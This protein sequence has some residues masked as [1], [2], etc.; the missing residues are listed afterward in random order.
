[1]LWQE[2]WCQNP[3][4]VSRLQKQMQRNVTLS[5]ED[6]NEC[7]SFFLSFLLGRMNSRWV[8]SSGSSV[9]LRLGNQEL[10]DHGGAQNSSHQ[11]FLMEVDEAP[12]AACKRG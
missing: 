10:Y 6:K 11:D 2:G 5:G 3:H 4:P 7:S 12:E 8:A 9:G 1:M